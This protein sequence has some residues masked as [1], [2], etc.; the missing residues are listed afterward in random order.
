MADMVDVAAE[1][2]SIQFE[3]TAL[4]LRVL[5]WTFM[6]WACLVSIYI[7]TGEKAGSQ[8]WLWSTI[9]LFVAGAIC[10]GVAQY[11]HI[12]SVHLMASLRADRNDRL[13]AA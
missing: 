5:G 8:L 4:V 11:F 13:R 1:D 7:W 6:I 2:R 9:G 3:R 10:M 12:R